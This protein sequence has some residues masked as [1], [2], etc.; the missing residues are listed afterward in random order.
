MQKMSKNSKIW[1]I[2]SVYVMLILPWLVT[3]VDFILRIFY[4]DINFY[5]SALFWLIIVPLYL[6]ALWLF[7]GSQEKQN[8]FVPLVSLAI[9]YVGLCLWLRGSGA[10]FWWEHGRLLDE[11]AMLWDFAF[12]TFA[13]IMGVIV[14]DFVLKRKKRMGMEGKIDIKKIASRELVIWTVIAA[15]LFV[16]V[17]CTMNLFFDWEEVFLKL[18]GIHMAAL[19]VIG[20]VSGIRIKK[21]TYLPLIACAMH[22][23]EL[24]FTGVV[25]VIIKDRYMIYAPL[26]LMAV[27][28]LLFLQFC[29][30][31]ISFIVTKQMVELADKI[32][33]KRISRNN[34]EGI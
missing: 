15:V 34:S 25:F 11:D 9:Y 26:V 8:C 3:A 13:M 27:A 23:M 14:G 28:F 18:W 5:W 7:Y 29:G 10:V 17:P 33:E 19:I 16:G 12:V 1:I 31:T 20:V 30:V 21:L 24:W 32:K 22:L 2:L 4:P 6:F